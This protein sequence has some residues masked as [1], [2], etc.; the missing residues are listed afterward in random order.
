MYRSDLSPRGNDGR[1]VGQVSWLEA[2]VLAF[3]GI[4]APSG[5]HEHGFRGFL[6]PL[7]V[8]GPRRT[9]TGFLL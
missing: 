1:G 2:A 8:A 7:T 9:F 5:S 4:E 3:P 6:G